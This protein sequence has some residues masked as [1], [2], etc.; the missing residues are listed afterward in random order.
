MLLCMHRCHACMHAHL[1]RLAFWSA[2]SGHALLPGLAVQLDVR[3]AHTPPRGGLRAPRGL[4]AAHTHAHARGLREA[5]GMHAARH[6][7]PRV[8]PRLEGH[9]LQQA[10]AVGGLREALLLRLHAAA[11]GQRR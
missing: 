11:A 9:H 1:Q 10:V 5:H 7:D 3:S 8:V 6:H 2:L 4:G